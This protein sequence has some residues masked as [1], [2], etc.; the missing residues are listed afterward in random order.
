MKDYQQ[1]LLDWDGN[2]AMTLDAWMHATHAPLK[3]RGIVLPDNEVAHKIFGRVSEGFAEYGITDI[4]AAVQEMVDSAHE[5]LPQVELYPDAL[6]TLEELKK[7][8]KQTALITTSLHQSVAHVL[9]KYEIRGLFDVI[10]ANEDT[11]NHKPHPEPLELA[12]EQLGGSKETAIMIGDSD[13]DIGAATNAGI[14]SILFYPPEHSR[15]YD[16]EQLQLHGPTY[17]VNDFR[18]ILGIIR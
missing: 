15:F 4:D 17:T 12:I 6:Y 11:K 8:G 13:K 1:I 9:D 10:I 7:S 14:D 16:L 2:L 3:K 18:K 5:L